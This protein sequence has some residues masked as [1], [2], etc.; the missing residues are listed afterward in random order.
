MAD[1]ISSGDQ[2]ALSQVNKLLQKYQ[3]LEKVVKREAMQRHNLVENLAHKQNQ[4]ELQA[5][6][7]RL[8]AQSVAN[9]IE[10]QPDEYRKIIWGLVRDERKEAI[11]LV[12]SDAVRV[13]LVADIKPSDKDNTFRMFDLHEGR[14]RQIPVT[15]REDL[16]KAKP[17][18]IDM[19]AP[20]DTQVALVKEI[21][22]V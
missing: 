20:E 6:L 2:E 5:L 4:A 1:K 3:L 14:L 9:I 10:T 19:V 17:I 7:D 11:L 22:G 8:G 12:L 18:W 21:F 13:E 16:Q 15:S